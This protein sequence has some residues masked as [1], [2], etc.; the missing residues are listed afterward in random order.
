VWTEIE[1]KLDSKSVPQMG[2][3]PQASFF[4]LR[5]GFAFVTALI[6]V[7][8]LSALVYLGL[9]SRDTSHIAQQTNQNN[10]V[11]V[12]QPP[13][14]I[15]TGVPANIEPNSTNV[16][17]SN[18]NQTTTGLPAETWQVETIAGE[19]KLGDGT[20][21]AKIA[22]GEL[23]E[24]DARSSARIAV[25]DIGSVDVAPN[26]RVK[27]VGTGK[28]EHRLSLEQGRLHAKIYAPPRLFVVDT[29]SG[30]AVDLGCEY[31]LEVDKKGNTILHVTGGYVAL[32]REGRESIVPAGM[33]CMT[34]RGR[35]LGTPFS[36]EATAGFRKA[37]EQFDFSGG[38]NSSLQAIL[39]EANFYDMVTLWH[40]LSR[41][42]K[43]DR[44][45]VYD[46]LAKFVK[47]PSGV[48]REGIIALDK[49][50]LEKWRTDVETAWFS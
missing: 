29:P 13:T 42:G 35:G 43:S 45:A 2:L 7:S 34:K 44:G 48:T 9:F 46:E 6:A 12:S 25:A 26:S 40:L 24:T 50:M 3:M 8:A 5:K 20:E 21:T 33:M 36:A 23:L 16:N 38:G 37:L 49:K 17:T 41:V 10:S 14:N 39:K 28:D 30:K 47:P 15:N 18:T 1:D 27:L 31:T 11:N 22:V 19:P 4:N 32:E